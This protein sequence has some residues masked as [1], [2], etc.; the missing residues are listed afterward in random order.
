M[1]ATM[2]DP[3]IMTRAIQRWRDC[4]MEYVDDVILANIGITLE[5]RQRLF[6]ETVF[7]NKK[8]MCSTHFSFG[9]SFL[10]AIVILTLANLYCDDIKGETYAPT[11]SQVKDILWA[12]LRSIREELEG[13]V[14]VSGKMLTVRYD[15]GPNGFITGRSPKRSAK[16][17]E[18]AQTAQGKHARVVLFIIDEAGG[19]DQQIIE[20]I[21]RSAASGQ[22][23]F[24]IAIGNPLSLSQW[25]GQYCTTEKGEGYTI[26]EF[27]AYSAPNMIDNKLISM[28]AMRMEAEKIRSLSPETRK[29]YY[30]DKFYKKSYP[31]LLSPGWV[32]QKYLRLGESGLFKS[33]IG[34]WSDNAIDT[35]IPMKRAN[36]CMLGSYIDGKGVKQWHSE[37]NDFCRWNGITKIRVG[38]DC[39]GEGTDRNILYA[40]EGNRELLFKSFE[41]TW[42]TTDEKSQLDYRGTYLKENGP[43]IA[44]YIYDNIILANPSRQIDITIDGT[45][46][47][48]KTV[49]DSLMEYK[50]DAEF[51]TIRLLNFASAAKDEETYHDVIAEMAWNLANIIKS[52]AGLLLEPNDDLKNQLTSRK[53][54]ADGKK[55]NM[56]ESKRDYKAHGMVSPDDFDALMLAC[57]E[58]GDSS[59]MEA[60]EKINKLQTKSYAAAVRAAG[61]KY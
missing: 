11:F 6:L 37:D 8:V 46:G 22:I 39:A 17:A 61:R 26:L 53:T 19:T 23:V 44:K 5:P 24:I 16:G 12:E 32:M 45:G 52:P 40:L 51:I 30:S 13:N 3:D 9:K 27:D 29:E 49:Y 43:Y 10:C 28:E 38:L 60:F 2:I 36:E 54:T 56:L 18:T 21:E 4:P 1:T 34:E 15:F 50:L 25:F 58:D 57:Y 7:K 42:E 55:R 31:T 59:N 47:F 35:L 41:K 33:Y 48:G 20:Q 14:A